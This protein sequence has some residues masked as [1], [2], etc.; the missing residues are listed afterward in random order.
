MI[1]FSFLSLCFRLSQRLTRKG[2]SPG[3]SR[4]SSCFACSPGKQCWTCLCT[5]RKGRTHLLRCSALKCHCFD[6]VPLFFVCCTSWTYGSNSL[7]TAG[8]VSGGVARRGQRQFPMTPRGLPAGRIGLVSPSGI[9]GA[10]PRHTLTSPVM[11][12]QG[13]QVGV[14][15]QKP[16]LDPYFMTLNQLYNI[17]CV[18]L[19]K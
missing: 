10:S 17:L 13:R 5:A 7:P 2:W 15:F 18:F 12:G 16:A 9:G 19:D 14:S 6:G 11:A 3:S 8:S 1:L 4:S